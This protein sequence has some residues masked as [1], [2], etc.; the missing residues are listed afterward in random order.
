M[1]KIK[2]KYIAELVS[3][4]FKIN[5][6]ELY[7]RGQQQPLCFARQV[8]MTLTYKYTHTTLART[9]LVYGR[10]HHTT[11][12][13]GIY[14]VAKMRKENEAI[15]N[16]ITKIETSCRKVIETFQPSVS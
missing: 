5:E 9:G 6:W 1:N 2:P 13:N 8:A 7:E 3:K 12:S 10:L 11:V 15:D 14:T 4:T 16:A